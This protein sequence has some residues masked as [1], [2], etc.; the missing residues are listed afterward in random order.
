MRRRTTGGRRVRRQ[1]DVEKNGRK[2]REEKGRTGRQ[3]ITFR[4]PRDFTS[5]DRPWGD[6]GSGINFTGGRASMPRRL[7]SIRSKYLEVSIFWE[8]RNCPTSEIPSAAFLPVL[9]VEEAAYVGPW[10]RPIC[11][12]PGSRCVSLSSRRKERDSSCVALFKELDPSIRG[13]SK[14]KKHEQRGQNVIGNCSSHATLSSTSFLTFSHS[15]F[16]FRFTVATRMFT[17]FMVV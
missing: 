6:D 5:R 16:L 15:A 4:F 14:R 13:R 10:S 11:G 2:S 9:V 3:G 17:L 1:I 8:S 12:L 7:A